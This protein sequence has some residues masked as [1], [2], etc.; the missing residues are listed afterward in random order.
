M[1]PKYIVSLAAAVL[2]LS[3]IAS[4]MQFAMRSQVQSGKAVEE[5][6]YLEFTLDADSTHTYRINPDLKT[7]LEEGITFVSDGPVRINS[8]YAA[9]TPKDVSWSEN[10]Q[11]ITSTGGGLAARVK[12]ETPVDSANGAHGNIFIRFPDLQELTRNVNFH[13][14]SYQKDDRGRWVL[15]QVTTYRNSVSLSFARFVFALAAGLPFAIVLQSVFWAFQLAR[16][17]KSRIA[18]FP[19]QGSQL[20]RIYY[21]D[22]IA[23]WTIWTLLVGIISGFMASMLAG[24]SVYDGFLSSSMI[25]FIYGIVAAGAVIAAVC[26]Y[27]TG[28]Y[29]LTVRVDADSISYARGRGDLQWVTARWA[30]V[31]QATQKSR[32]YRGTRREWVEIEFRDKRKKLKLRETIMGYPALRDFIFS[33]FTQRSSV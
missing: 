12:W 10:R 28:A 16:E 33:L 24:F 21:P 11:R 18:A 32:T 30:D 5:T 20:P 8:T 23:E 7:A 29:L 15:R 13:S 14:G 6:W 31:L 25:W 3:A 27:F 2:I 19:Q 17:K 1:I 22:P 4:T 26:A 9:V